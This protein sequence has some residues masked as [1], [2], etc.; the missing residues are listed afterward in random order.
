MT[1]YLK[2]DS[3]V[4][5][6]AGM[7][8]VTSEMTVNDVTVSLARPFVQIGPNLAVT[9]NLAPTEHGVEIRL[10]EWIVMEFGRSGQV[11]MLPRVVRTQRVAVAMGRAFEADPSITWSAT[12]QQLTTW[13]QNWIAQYDAGGGGR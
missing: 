11:T 9:P 10:D 8:S 5:N 3:H 7:A 12:G 1:G 13:C 4:F 2:L 6:G